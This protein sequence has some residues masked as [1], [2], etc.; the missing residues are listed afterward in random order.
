MNNIMNKVNGLASI[1][2]SDYKTFQDL[3][4]FAGE[5]NELTEEF[6]GYKILSIFYGLKKEEASKLRPEEFDYMLGKVQEAFKEESVLRSIINYKG[7]DYG[8]IPKFADITTGELIDLDTLLK[9]EKHIE[10][11]SILYR[12]LVGKVSGNSEYYIEDYKGYNEV[13]KDVDAFTMLSTLNFFTQSF[14]ILN[15]HTNIS[16]EVEKM[17]ME[18]LKMK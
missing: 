7:V 12:P 3:V 8:L 4:V 5:N 14:Q 15:L 6:L 10:L 11:L 2:W 1:K 16:M 18:N 9:E 17:E 13:F